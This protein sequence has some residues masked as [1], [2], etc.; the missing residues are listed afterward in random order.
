MSLGPIIPGLAR[1]RAESD[2]IG[3]YRCN[4]EPAEWVTHNFSRYE[5]YNHAAN[6][7]GK[8]TTLSAIAAGMVVGIPYLHAFD[9]SEIPIPT[10]EPRVSIGVGT[11]TYKLGEGSI[12]DYIRAF[13][14]TD[15]DRV[16]EG[17]TTAGTSVFHVKHRLSRAGDYRREWSVIYVFPYDGPTPEEV[18]LDAW[19]ADGPPPPDW[20]GAIRNRGKRGRP[21]YGGIAATPVRSS[22]WEPLVE[23]YPEVKRV[24]DHRGRVSVQSSVYDNRFLHVPGCPGYDQGVGY[25]SCRCPDIVRQE[26]A[27]EGRSDARARL[28]GEHVNTDSECPWDSKLLDSWEVLCV[29]PREVIQFVVQGERTTT[30]GYSLVELVCKLE[31]W[32]YE[33]PDDEYLILMDP[34]TGQ[35]DGRHDPD[36]LHV[37]SRRTRGLVARVSQYLG[38]WGLGAAGVKIA[39]AYGNGEFHVCRGG[40]YGD[41]VLSAARVLGYDNLGRDRAAANVTRRSQLGISE[42]ETTRHQ[43]MNAV[44]SLLQRGTTRIPSRD[45]IRCLRRVTVKDGRIEGRGKNKDEDMILLGHG[46]RLLDAL[47]PLAEIVQRVSGSQQA[48]NQAFRND[49]GFSPDGPRRSLGGGGQPLDPGRW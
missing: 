1:L 12:L 42:N 34:G 46:D 28:F 30:L 24:P 19:F 29:P 39:E 41:S 6:S 48:F 27:N 26:N 5:I 23:E 16:K 2:P 22:E 37:R 33:D 43:A 35:N 47:G 21:L 10:P 8:T 17:R 3:T 40:G 32:E 15:P 18:R 14:G 31:V 44:T 9:G 13:I 45:V 11:P 20:L 36:G 25:C 38:A 4:G 7:S 49:F